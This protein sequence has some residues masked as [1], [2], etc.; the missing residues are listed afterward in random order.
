MRGKIQTKVSFVFFIFLALGV[1]ITGAIS[2]LLLKTTIPSSQIDSVISSKL[3]IYEL[4]SMAIGF[5]ISYFIGSQYIKRVVAPI[6]ELAKTTKKITRGELVK[7]EPIKSSQDEI[8]EL[9]VNFHLINKKLEDA[10]GELQEKNSNMD[11]VLKSMINGVIA[12]NKKREIVMVNPF[13]EEIFGITQEQVIG[14]TMSE[15]VF[16]K[17][18][19]E[20]IDSL[21]IENP[22]MKF[23]AEVN[24]PIYKICSFSCSIMTHPEDPTKFTGIAIIIQDITEIRKLENMRRDFV[25]NVS[26][27][28]QTPLTSIKGFLETLRE[29]RVEDKATRDRF[30]DIITIETD[31]LFSLI[32]DILSLSEIENKER[33]DEK[34]LMETNE[35]IDDVIQNMSQ[36]ARIRDIKLEIVSP[37]KLTPIIG[38]KKWF[39]QMLINLLDNALKYTSD[40]GKV[41]LIAKEDDKNLIIKVRD[42]GMGIPKED[43]PRI[44][45]RFYRVD[46][47]RSREVG[48]TGLGLAIVKHVAIS[49]EGRVEVESEIDKGTE[50]TVTIP[51]CGKNK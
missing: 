20:K 19:T 46:K 32:Q 1:I 23:E 41:E 27:E 36:V 11:A 12:L 6:R 15:S 28:L 8:G 48:G 9:S 49:M 42:N 4:L 30:L 35:I 39:K 24:F 34:E 22:R 33:Q 16:S 29:G 17:N 43:Q 40:G 47:A 31:R 5:I 44:F 45:E 7:S 13:A 14:K 21:S 38:N 10:I 51:I 18:I 37:V 50:F 2:L 3:V 26:H 25:A